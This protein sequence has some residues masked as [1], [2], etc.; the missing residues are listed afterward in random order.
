MT[1][2]ARRMLITFTVLAV[3]L[4]ALLAFAA[5]HATATLNAIASINTRRVDVAVPYGPLPRQRLDVYKPSSTAP[6]GGYPL[7][8]FF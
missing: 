4:A 3:G 8:V 2:P 6:A 5:T 1:G 7:V